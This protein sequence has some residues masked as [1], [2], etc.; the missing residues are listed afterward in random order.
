MPALP[1]PPSEIP[2]LDVSEDERPCYLDSAATSLKPRAVVDRLAR[3]YAYE[4]APVHRSV[5]E[6]SQR[7]T[8]AYEQARRTVA[9][10]VHAEPEQVVFTRGTTEGLNLIAH[11]WAME[12][13]QPGDELLVSPQEHHSNFLPWQA[14]AERTG[15]TLHYFPLTP[16]GL[17]DLDEARALI[18]RRTKLVA[19]AH[20]SNVL[21]V[22]NPVREVFGA[23]RKVGAITVL[24]G[25]QSV[26]TRP[27]DLADLHCDALAFSGHKMLG[28]TGI[29]ALVVDL[30]RL[31]PMQPYQTGGG[32]IERVS[33]SAPVYLDGVARFEAG[34]PHAAGA[35]G[36]AAAC[37]YLSSLT[38]D[39]KTGM[40]AVAAYEHAWGL[41][42]MEQIGDIDGLRTIV[43]ILA[44][45]LVGEGLLRFGM[46]YLTQWIGQHALYDLRTTVF[47]HVQQQR[48][49][50]FDTT[51]LGRLI[52]R[53]TNDIAALATLLSAG[54]VT[55]L[56]DLIRLLFIASFMI[57]LNWE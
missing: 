53:T 43:L 2:L 10:F 14:V 9:A 13:L 49:G 52:T 23:A 33:L 5:Y 7:A 55:M 27:V 26:P 32:M 47:R 22:E 40:A 6:L 34:T 54:V 3:F 17:V 31:G 12:Q 56:G 18:C 20:V 44:A 42:A 19:M 8:D 15:A 30:A 45:V 39:G 51:P 50:F 57:A 41:H 28:P 24:D 36:L 37:D 29:G 35:I 1:L 46:G 4:N 21:G 38:Y 16:T 25:A 48:L 11:A